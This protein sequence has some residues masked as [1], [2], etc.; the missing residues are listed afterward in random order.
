[1]PSEIDYYVCDKAALNKGFHSFW[2]LVSGFLNTLTISQPRIWETIF[3]MITLWCV[4][5]CERQYLA[6]CRLWRDVTY[7]LKDN[8]VEK[9]TEGKHALEQRQRE[10]AKERKEAGT[11][12]ETKVRRG[13]PSG[14]PRWGEGGQVGNQ[15]EERVAKWETKVRRGW[16]SGKPKWGEGE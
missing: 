3:L 16:P 7:N 8:N 13:W 14:K 2:T 15:G 9:A 6:C 10:E 4:L 1:M 5:C 12:W 11:N